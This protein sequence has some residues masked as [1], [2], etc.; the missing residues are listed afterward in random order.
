[1]KY[2]LICA[3]IDGTLL[4]DNKK[5]LPEV[6]SS[7]R[8]AAEKGVKIALVSGRMPAGIS[9]IE[10]ELGVEC[11]KACNA[12]TYI[13]QGSQCISSMYLEP[14][15][16][17][18][19][20]RNIAGRE[21][22][23]LWIFRENQWFVTDIDEYIEQEI[24]IIRHR[25][26]IADIEKLADQWAGEETGPNKLL[27]AARPE[28]IRRIQKEIKKQK[29]RDIDIACS[30][31]TFLEVFPKGVTKGT[32]LMKICDRLNIDAA[33]TIAFGDHE[34]DIPMIEAAGL[35]IAMGNAID[36]L[37]ARADFVT[38]SNN[39]AGIAYALERYL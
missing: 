5:L 37:K 33:E 30:A 21:K 19:F 6:R 23:P 18:D 22:I 10:E 29:R 13:L 7:L 32:A 9:S 24:K 11:V 39:E 35:G 12:G 34:L 27:V 4:D 28:V 38:K 14:E 1:M 25:P 8:K 15:I 16:M 31:D 36:K 3:D 17:K 20:Y 26:G 2:K